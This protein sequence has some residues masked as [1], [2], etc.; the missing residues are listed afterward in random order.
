M[1]ESGTEG[2]GERGEA[3][4]FSAVYADLHRLAELAFLDQRANHTLQPTALVHEAYL[5]MSRQPDADT[6]ESRRHFLN[7]AS[8]AMRQLLADHARA[9]ATDK[10]GGGFQRVQIDETGDLF[11][12]EGADLVEL[13]EL[14]ERLSRVNQRQAKLIE[15]RFLLGLSVEETA[16]MLEVSKRTVM[17]DW[18]AARGWLKQELG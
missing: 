6:W 15:Y 3:L 9:R 8:L 2:R 14:L 4:D 13:A 7:V 5:R 18:K 11:G 12:D 17:L 1:S 16:Q 10:R